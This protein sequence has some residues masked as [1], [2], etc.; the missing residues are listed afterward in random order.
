M[1]QVQLQPTDQIYDRAKRRAVEAGF[2]SVEEYA[3]EVLTNDLYEDTGDYDRLFTPERIAHLDKVAAEV[4]AGGK[5][6]TM[7]EVRANL[8]QNRAEWIRKNGQ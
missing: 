6:Y 2:K 3:S 1:H 4:R 8:A 7:Q 5:T